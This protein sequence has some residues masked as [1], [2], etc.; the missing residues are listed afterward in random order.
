LLARLYGAALTKILIAL[1]V[2]G[3]AFATLEDW[4]PLA[5]FGAY[6]AVQIIPA[7]LA[8]RPVAHSNSSTP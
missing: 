3:L 1:A 4:N 6:L 5:M 7:L 2:F 8:Q